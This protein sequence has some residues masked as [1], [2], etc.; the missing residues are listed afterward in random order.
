[1]TD[2]QARRT[3]Y[4]AY[5]APFALYMLLTSLESADWVRLGYETLYGFKVLAVAGALIAFRR[6]YPRFSTTG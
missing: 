2:T 4:A 6:H 5:I 1:M 3:Q